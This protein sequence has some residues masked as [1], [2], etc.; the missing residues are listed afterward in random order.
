MTTISAELQAAL[1]LRAKE[2]LSHWN[3]SGQTPQ[4]VKY[5]EN[6]VFKVEI[7]GQ[8]AALR[9]HRAGYHQEASLKSELTWMSYLRSKGLPVPGLLPAND[10]KFLARLPNN[11]VFEEQY[12]DV[13]CWVYGERIGDVGVPLAFSEERLTRIFGALGAEIAQMHN[14]A[15]EWAMPADFERHAWDFQGL[16]GE[17]PFWGRFWDCPDLLNEQRDRLSRLR[18]FLQPK[19]RLIEASGLDYGMIHAD[20]VRE[21]VIVD[22]D[23]IGLLDFDDCGFGWRVFDLA[24]VLFGHRNERNYDLIKSSLLSGYCSRR[25]LREED[26]AA[27]PIFILLRSLTYVGWIAERREI[28]GSAGRLSYFVDTCLSLAS[29]FG[30]D[31]DLS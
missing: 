5:R 18:V 21:N 31:S 29:S 27:L 24:T 15:D 3:A 14:A 13:M 9:I 20:L 1:D 28:P 17:T 7:D 26:I 2:A 22:G 30:F 16:L 12:A 8:P 25:Q 4:L 6:A 23:S 11:I 19:L 10:G